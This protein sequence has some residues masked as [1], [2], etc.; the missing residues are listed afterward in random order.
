[1]RRVHYVNSSFL[2][3]DRTCKALLRYCRALAVAGR[4]DVVE[5]PV[6]TETGDVATAH[7][8]IGPA[9]EIF[10]VPVDAGVDDPRD[11]EV[12]AYLER[13]TLRLQPARP[14]W[15]EEMTDVPDLDEY[16]DLQEP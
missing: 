1:M 16:P 4:S 12:T 10:S 11:D 8:L 6:I 3:A 15:G 14:A 5:V 2:V 13:E 7:L 9:S